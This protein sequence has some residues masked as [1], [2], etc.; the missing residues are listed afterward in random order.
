MSP[1]LCN[2]SRRLGGRLPRK[3]LKPCR[4][5]APALV[6]T[7]LSRIKHQDLVDRIDL[8]RSLKLSA[9]VS[10]EVTGFRQIALLHQLKALC[11]GEALLHQGL[12]DLESAAAALEI[13]RILVELLLAA[14]TAL[15]V[16]MRIELSRPAVLGLAAGIDRH[17]DGHGKPV[18]VSAVGQLKLHAVVDEALKLIIREVMTVVGALHHKPA[19]VI[20]TNVI[21]SSASHFHTAAGTYK[22]KRRFS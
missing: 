19:L 2:C 17:L 18:L 6:S 11:R 8:Y 15:D 3:L 9:V 20:R 10:V 13:V 7:G 1:V 21:P 14:Q 5:P 16:H 12:D 4:F 22:I